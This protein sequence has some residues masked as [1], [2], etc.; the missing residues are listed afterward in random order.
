[1]VSFFIQ[2]LHVWIRIRIHKAPNTDPNPQHWYWH[3]CMGVTGPLKKIKMLNSWIVL[4]GSIGP[5][6]GGICAKFVIETAHFF[7]TVWSN[8]KKDCVLPGKIVFQRVPIL[9]K[10]ILAF[11]FVGVRRYIFRIRII[12]RRVIGQWV[13]RMLS[14]YWRVH[15][16]KNCFSKGFVGKILKKIGIAEHFALTTLRRNDTICNIRNNSAFLISKVGT[17]LD[18]PA[19]VEYH[20]DILLLKIRFCLRSKF[21]KFLII[22]TVWS[23]AVHPIL[24]IGE[25]KFLL[26]VNL[27]GKTFELAFLAAS[28]FCMCIINPLV[29]IT[30]FNSF[31]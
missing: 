4:I 8:G 22:W 27:L 23:P 24:S 31:C 28:G 17:F 30:F 12:L 6:S 7:L 15:Y 21:S 9:F 5:S 14:Y 19:C 20:V 29:T 11:K 13:T 3:V 16:L 1:M 26:D 10:H 2:Y 18:T 25:C